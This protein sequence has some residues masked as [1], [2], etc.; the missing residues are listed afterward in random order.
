MVP[1]KLTR[2]RLL[3]AGGGLLLVVGGAVGV[4]RTHGYD[5]PAERAASLKSLAP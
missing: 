1:P 4:V 5:L 2:R 3:A